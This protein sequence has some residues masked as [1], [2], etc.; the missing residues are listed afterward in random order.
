VFCGKSAVAADELGLAGPVAS[1]DI[2]A[3]RAPHIQLVGIGLQPNLHHLLHARTL[4]PGSD[5]AHSVQ[6]QHWS[7][8][9]RWEPDP[10][11]EAVP[12]PPAGTK[13]ECDSSPA[14]ND[15]GFRKNRLKICE[16]ME[17]NPARSRLK[18]MTARTTTEGS[19]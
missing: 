10:T 17:P 14:L 12:A 6:Q 7:M 2:P 5:N 18:I 19:S 11:Y 1:V 3:L 13:T 9:P 8:S 16:W 4:K 15:P